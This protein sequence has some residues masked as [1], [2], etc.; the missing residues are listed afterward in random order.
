MREER[1]GKRERREEERE[2]RKRK[3]NR[4]DRYST[5]TPTLTTHQQSFFELSLSKSA[6]D[7]SNAFLCQPGLKHGRSKLQ[8]QSVPH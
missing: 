1:G 8:T 7:M 2:G 4:A 3:G 6:T 5:H